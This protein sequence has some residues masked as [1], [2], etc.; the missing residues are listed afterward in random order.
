MRIVMEKKLE[1]K[2]GIGSDLVT[3]MN[4]WSETIEASILDLGHRLFDT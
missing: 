4:S 3:S 1:T 2:L